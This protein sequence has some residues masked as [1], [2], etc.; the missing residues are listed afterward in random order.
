MSLLESEKKAYILNTYIWKKLTFFRNTV[1]DGKFVTFQQVDGTFL[2]VKLASVE[3]ICQSL[4][5][6]YVVHGKL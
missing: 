6:L 4:L 5:M 1:H 3:S 2:I